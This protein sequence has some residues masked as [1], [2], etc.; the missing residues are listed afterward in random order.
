MS[1]VL[2]FKHPA[3]RWEESMLIGNGH[4]GASVYGGYEIEKLALNV[5]TFWSDTVRDDTVEGRE[6]YIKEFQEL[7]LAGKNDEAQ[8]LAKE[9]LLHNKDAA[10]Y[11][12][13]G[14]ILIERFDCNYHTI[15]K[16]EMTLDMSTGIATEEYLYDDML[17]SINKQIRKTYISYP[18]N[19]LI[20]E[21]KTDLPCDFAVFYHTLLKHSVACD[22]DSL[23]ALSYA[24]TQNKRMAFDFPYVYKDN[25]IT[26]GLNVKAVS[27]GEV[28]TSDD[29]I[30]IK[31][32]KELRL[33][34]TGETNF[35]AWNVLPDKN[36]DI[37]GVCK[38][39]TEKVLKDGF[40]K[41]YNDHV[42]YHSNIYNRMTFSLS[43]CKE[44]YL[45]DMLE[46]Y[47]K[48]IKNNSIIEQLF[49]FGRYLLIASS[50][51][52]SQPANLQGIWNNKVSPM[53]CSDYTVNIN[54]QMN[55]WLAEPC[56]LSECHEP[57]MKMLEEISISGEKTAKEFYGCN[58]FV[59][60]HNVDLWRKTSP[61]SGQP[62]WGL[63]PVGGAWLCQNLWTKYLYTQDKEYLKDFAYPLLKKASQFFVDFM[64]LDKEGYYVTLPSVSPENTY[65]FEGTRCSVTK[66]SVMDNVIITDLF[67]NT[68][69]AAEILGDK[70]EMISKMGEMLKKFS[71]FEIG[72]EGQLLEWDKEYLEY[73]RGHRH[74]S[75][76]CG[77]FP[78]DILKRDEKI[79]EASRKSLDIRVANGGGYTGWSGAWM[80]NLFASLEDAEEA[81]YFV[82]KVI[83]NSVYPNFMDRHAPFQIDGNFGFTM[84]VS[85]MILQS[86]P[87][88]DKLNIVVLPACPDD[89]V[90]GKM[91][92]LRTVL[93]TEA[94]VEWDNKK[95]VLSLSV[96]CGDTPKPV[97][98]TYKDQTKSITLTDKC[99]V[100]FEK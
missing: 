91:T 8:E 7:Y 73:D 53:W 1:D 75:H 30:I 10:L 3:N 35:V 74:V 95:V 40:E 13:A 56:N 60:H 81:S 94:S 84:G 88:N 21:L 23:S 83:K 65:Y 15:Q 49:K 62:D 34:I 18:H 29:R 87:Y 14:D 55:Y 45:E 44:T 54:L 86:N 16:G 6:K 89:W 76:L 63:W 47:K 78:Y 5:D 2:K 52:G 50:T 11:L 67:E 93:G 85:Q 25:S 100:V 68:I 79:K 97:E 26:C 71:P 72:T 42:E 20:F 61:A 39:R 17:H 31:Q 96:V 41:V 24:P 98:I 19:A 77:I 9:K 82:D 92:G 38:K 66:M 48:G 46:D 4:L 27:D 80:I 43:G 33:I 51:P 99:E 70:D 32:A 57:L 22:K 64:I 69:K 37:I 12:P 58:G 59:C 90:S 28:L 36:K